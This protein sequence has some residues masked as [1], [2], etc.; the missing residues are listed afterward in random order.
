MQ[1]KM[2]IDIGNIPCSCEGYVTGAVSRIFSFLQG[3][4]GPIKGQQHSPLLHGPLPQFER[5]QHVPL[6]VDERGPQQLQGVDPLL[7]RDHVGP[8]ADEELHDVDVAGHGG[9][10]KG[11]HA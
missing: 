8:R 10:E 5:S 6:L 11:G 4:M 2:L 1:R 9:G 3:Q 7:A